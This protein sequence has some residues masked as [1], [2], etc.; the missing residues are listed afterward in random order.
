[1]LQK[2]NYH[3]ILFMLQRTSLLEKRK[4]KRNDLDKHISTCRGKVEQD[5]KAVNK[6][7]DADYI[8]LENLDI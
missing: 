2:Q 3:E 1:M 6:K 4:K 7:S 8:D 5:I